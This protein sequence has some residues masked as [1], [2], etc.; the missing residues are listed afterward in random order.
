MK[1]IITFVS[2]TL[3]GH[4]VFS[5]AGDWSGTG[6]AGYNSVSGNSNTESLALGLDG[7]YETGKW[8][9]NGEIDAYRSSQNDQTNAK[10]YGLELESD[11]DLD[12]K[13]FVF[14]N[15]RYL[16]DQFSGYEYQASLTLGAGRTFIED[17]N[18]LFSGQIGAGYRKSEPS[19]NT[20]TENEPV[21]SAQITYNRD[22]TDTTVFESSWEAETGSDNTYLEGGIAVIVAMTE[23]LGIKLSYTA[24][25]NTDVP[26]G[27]KNTDRFT[28]VSLNY[29]FK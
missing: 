2:L 28:T 18:H 6:D 10:S 9:Y 12:E 11:Y 29:K 26:V 4:S 22:L 14:S 3:L 20:G 8:T 24:K 19:G 1:I 7:R 15:I 13:T 23:A 21:A 5:Q 27:S 17:G 25:R 16:D